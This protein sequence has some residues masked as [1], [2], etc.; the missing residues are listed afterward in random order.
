MIEIANTNDRD[1]GNSDLACF[2]LDRLP[3]G[4]LD[5]QQT[6]LS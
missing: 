2:V 4:Y 3:A 6:K 1:D 5:R